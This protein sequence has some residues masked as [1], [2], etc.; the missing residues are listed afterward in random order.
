VSESLAYGAGFQFDYDTN[1]NRLMSANFYNAGT[2]RVNSYLDG[3]N[4]ESF[5][6]FTDYYPF[7][8]GAC[9]ILATNIYNPGSVVVGADG[10]LWLTGQ[11]VDLSGGSFS[12]E[13]LPADTYLGELDTGT[14]L[15]STTV[16]FSP[17]TVGDVGLNSGGWYPGFYLAANSAEGSGPDYLTLTNSTAYMKLDLNQLASNNIIRAVFILNNSGPNVTYNVYF[18]NLANTDLG[19]EA[20]TGHIEWVGTSTDPATGVTTTNYLYLTDDYEFGASTNVAV[21][22]GVPDNFS[23]IEST[24]PLLVGLVPAAAGFDP[25]FN[26][27]AVT[28]YYDN[29]DGQILASTVA[30]NATAMNPSGAITNLYGRMQITATKELN[31]NNAIFSGEN[32]LSLT[33]TNQF[34]GSAGA[35][36]SS[37]YADISLGV[38]NGFL[39]ISNLLVGDL[40]NWNGTI[41]AWSSRWI[42]VDP[43]GVTNDYRVLLVSNIFEPTSPIWVHNLSL[44][45]TNSLVLS[46]AMN[47]YGSLYIDASSMTLT[48]NIFG[49]GATSPDG[50]LDCDFNGGLSPTQFPNLRWL[51]NNG[52]ISAPGQIILTN[53]ASYGA[54]INNGVISGTGMTIYTTNFLNSGIITNL[55][56]NLNIQ[57]QSTTLSNGTVSAIGNISITT[58]NFL[59][60]STLMQCYALTLNPSNSLTDTGPGNG[61]IWVVGSTNAT[62]GGLSLLNYPGNGDLLGTTITNVCPPPNK[63]INNYWAGTNYGISTI[64]FSNNAALGHLI[65]DVEG[66][67][68]KMIFNGTGTNNALYVDCLEL[69]GELSYGITNSYDFSKYLSVNTNL[70]IYFAQALYNGVS[71]AERI[72]NASL[73][74][75][76]NGASTNNGV[77]TPGRLLWVPGYAGYF[78]STN[79]VIGG[80][81]NSFN[82]ALAASHDYDSNGNGTPN[83][84]DATPFFVPQLMN[85][86]LTIT[87]Q[88]SRRSVLTFNTVPYATNYV[89]YTTNLLSG[90]W[91]P[92]T[93][94]ASTTVTGP[95]YPVSVF[96]TNAT[97]GV[98]FYRVQVNPWLLNTY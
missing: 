3:N 97:R 92:F 71:I 28:N 18:D 79:L 24:T 82:A 88:P 65:L 69:T 96:D 46:D 80:V 40:P 51:T 13:S 93:N 2:V 14:S 45:S 74:G 44:H 63:T 70:V 57:S 10:L 68:S 4:T 95:A 22:G 89:T 60:T 84:Q 20:G 35:S 27:T 12:I 34:D 32:Y 52:V 33:A 6:G 67:N 56:G 78:S 9:N 59:A 50:Q 76:K 55:N 17:A 94:F 5:D 62:G 47:V 61:N 54:V 77:V 26:D 43:T 8:L 38:T 83:N 75:G 29:F 7:S 49:F 87:N 66:V 41:C 73:T 58:G 15:L 81:T 36:I 42:Y 25:V 21:V 19:F 86:T 39:T 1:N 30:T 48:T 11:N 91:L 23:F 90:I 85:F 37:P 53:K 72:N 98:R 31:L 64:G 16:V